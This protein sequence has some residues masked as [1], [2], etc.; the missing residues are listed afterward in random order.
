MITALFASL[1][2]IAL[3]FISIKTIN[4]YSKTSSWVKTPIQIKEVNVEKRFESDLKRPYAIAILYSYKI[5]GHF[6]SSSK[7]HF[8]EV[9][10]SIPRYNLLAA[11]SL[12]IQ[13]KSMKTAF[14]YVNPNNPNEAF[15]FKQNL[16]WYYFALIGGIFALL[17]G[18]VKLYGL[19]TN[20]GVN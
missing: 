15:L 3:L 6:Y 9:L 10:G 12:R 20:S 17:F 1:L 19:L 7:V 14:A 2:G 16:K 13:L 11:E 18:C 5:D 4:S 8:E